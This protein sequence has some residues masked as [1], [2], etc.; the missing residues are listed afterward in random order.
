[1]RAATLLRRSGGGFLP[2]Q[3]PGLKTWL[4]ADALTGLADLDPVTTWVDSS[5]NANNAAMTT[6]PLHRPLYR[7]GI[8]NGTPVLRFDGLGDSMLTPLLTMRTFFAVVNHTDGAAFSDFRRIFGGWGPGGPNEIS[9]FGMH[10]TTDYNPGGAYPGGFL[11]TGSWIN[12][13][14]GISAAPLGSFRVISGVAAQS[15]V[16]R[17]GIGAYLGHADALTHAQTLLG[18]MAEFMIYDSPLTTAQRRQVE[19][20]LG[21]KY[22]IA[23]V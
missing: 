1:M 18:D 10:P 11:A 15:W 16:T 20:Y 6:N 21:A 23:V 4:K 13:G 3:I 5:G 14:V 2:P 17:I 19:S 9:Y 12:G 22:G 7:T 8:L